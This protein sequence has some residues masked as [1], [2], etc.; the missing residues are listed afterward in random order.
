MWNGFRGAKGGP[1]DVVHSV[2]SAGSGAN[3][4]T[5]LGYGKSLLM[6]SFYFTT[7]CEDIFSLW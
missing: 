2:G 3:G 6:L 5:H 4:V 7:F 1:G